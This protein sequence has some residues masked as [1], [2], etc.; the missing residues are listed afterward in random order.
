MASTLLRHAADGFV[1]A[2]RAVERL[3]D[4]GDDG[5][6]QFGGVAEIF[7]HMVMKQPLVLFLGI[8][9]LL[10]IEVV[11][12]DDRKVFVQQ[13]LADAHMQ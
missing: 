6:E 3:H 7:V 5:F 1:A 13:V 4:D 2:F 11:R 9:D 10:V 8:T 12:P